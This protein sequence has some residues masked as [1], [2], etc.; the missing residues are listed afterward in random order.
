MGTYFLRI[1]GLVLGSVLFVPISCT[2]SLI[3]GAFAW[4]G[5]DARDISKGESPHP[6]FYVIAF[7][8]KPNGSLAAI[9]LSEIERG[10][11]TSE[12]SFLLPNLVGKFRTEKR[13]QQFEYSVTPLSPE[14]QLVEVHYDDGD[15]ISISR[16]IAE[17]T[18]VEPLYSK[19]G[20]PVYV[21]I[22][23][24]FLA[25]VFA[26]MLYRVGKRLRRRYRPEKGDNTLRL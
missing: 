17:D 9:H 20:F 22:P 8:P 7:K 15:Y 23:T 6:F 16:Y 24:I 4:R 2:S 13:D 11:D 1:C 3:L 18:K 5:L 14:K 10:I 19:L 12:Y 21:S 25:W 26:F